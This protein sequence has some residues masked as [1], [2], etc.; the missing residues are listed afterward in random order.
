[1][2]YYLGYVDNT[3]DYWTAAGIS[4]DIYRGYIGFYG[5]ENELLGQQNYYFI[6]T[7]VTVDG[8]LTSEDVDISVLY[9]M[10]DENSDWQGVHIQG[11]TGGYTQNQQMLPISLSNAGWTSPEPTGT[12]SSF[13]GIYDYIDGRLYIWRETLDAEETDV[14][15]GTL[16]RF[17][18]GRVLKGKFQGSSLSIIDFEASLLSA[19]GGLKAT[20]AALGT[21]VTSYLIL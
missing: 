13:N 17:T 18:R 14:Q 1:M 6:H 10:G 12:D 16:T 7:F 20:L 19:V 11:T 4:D 21:V 9:Q 2:G 15:G 8:V 5:H 3:N